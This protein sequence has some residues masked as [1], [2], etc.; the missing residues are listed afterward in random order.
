[1]TNVATGDQAEAPA[2]Q[3]PRWRPF[4]SARGRILGWYIVIL[5]AALIAGLFVQRS[6][7]RNQVD[8]EVNE[9]LAQEL[10]ELEQ[11]SQGRD[12]NTGE[13]FAGDVAAI[14][15]TFLSRNVP[16]ADEALFTIVDGQPHASTVTPVQLLA[17]DELVAR[18]AS[19]TAPERDEIATEA[20]RARYLA[21]PLFGEDGGVAGVFAVVIFLEPR[22]ANV[23]NAVR[24]GAIVY[25]SS[26]LVASILA[27]VA[28]GH[29]LRPIRLL[30]NAARSTSAGNWRERIPVQGDDEIVELT[31]TFNEMVDRLQ[32]AFETQ[33]RFIDDAGHELRTPITIIRGHLE[34]LGDDPEEREEARHVVMDELDRMSRIVEDLLLLAKADAPGFL[35]PSVFDLD[36]FTRELAAR[37]NTLG[38]RTWEVDETARVNIVADRQRLTQAVM[39]L[40]RNAHEHT[41]PGTTVR[42]G[43]RAAG[44]VVCIWVEDDGPGIPIE[45][46][47]RIFDRFSRG[48]SGKRATEGAGLGLAI[49]DAIARAH[50]G[51]L[52]LDS[53]PGEGAKFSITLPVEENGDWGETG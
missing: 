14:F 52:E 30:T 46:Q 19:L 20:G 22:F 39:N 3:R 18:W 44:D 10:E 37:V 38:K 7:L 27:W 53:A 11:L 15:D 16:V 28:A 17:D 43:S 33:R 48:Q 45:E 26:F 2:R 40:M 6:V 13:P 36:T 8:S 21:A 42:I 32:A 23:D 47:E 5:A 34:L 1:M 31:R 41:P 12:P 50:G 25:G 29:V 35:A 51:R 9:Q 49:A 24:Q 4:A